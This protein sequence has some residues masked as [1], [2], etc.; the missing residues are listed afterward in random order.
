MITPFYKGLLCAGL[1]Q[2]L[3]SIL[4][5]DADFE[6]INS[7]VPILLAILKA[8]TQSHVE[9][10]ILHANLRDDD[11]WGY[12]IPN[13]GNINTESGNQTSLSVIWQEGLLTRNRLSNQHIM[14]VIPDLAQIN[15]AVSRA[16]IM[17]M[18]T[19][20]VCMQRHGQGCFWKPDITWV[21]AC[22]RNKI[23]RVSKHLLDRYALRLTPPRFK[24]KKNVSDITEWINSE[25]SE[26]PVKMHESEER[27]LAKLTEKIENAV[28]IPSS[29]D[30]EAFERIMD[31]FPNGSSY[32]I[33][34]EST[35]ARMSQA[36]ARLHSSN[37]V[38]KWHVDE[39]ADIIGLV[40]TQDVMDELIEEP[41]DE[42]LELKPPGSTDQEP[43]HYPHEAET[44]II[45]TSRAETDNQNSDDIEPQVSEPEILPPSVIKDTSPYPEDTA[46]VERE[47]FS[48]Q[49][50]AR[51]H[52]SVSSERGVILGDQP[53]NTLTDIAL[54]PT[55]I[56]AAMFQKIRH[57]NDKSLPKDRLVISPADLRR[58]RRQA[59]PDKM[60]I[61]LI[62]YTCLRNCKWQDK[63]LPHL[64]WAY[65]NR[66]NVCIIQVGTED[67]YELH[68]KKLNA[69][70][71]LSPIISDAMD[72]SSG[73][74]TPL[75]HGLDLAYYTMQQNL[76][77]GREHISHTRF[78]VLTDGRGNVPLAV[79]QEGKIKI[80][81]NREG[82]N[83]ALNIA[84]KI[85]QLTK[86]QT[87]LL[88]P[89][90][91]YH[92]ELPILLA[93]ALGA[94]REPIDLYDDF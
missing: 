27:L 63:M 53:T 28:K 36:L 56:E 71:V 22:D 94:D 84:H 64:R 80:P 20:V 31:Y 39:A 8:G 35:L 57:I 16:C 6:N 49:L 54:V 24:N 46:V 44:G 73:K 38:K 2:R 86:V 1:H 32:G 87:F 92:A 85:Y 3:R 29:M 33:R 76:L 55:I 40:D 65:I 25:K 83:D 13:P 7:L 47:Q 26:F 52:L 9:T 5:L 14:V 18:D 61:L 67:G 62:D 70:T 74:A 81:V 45:D 75:A 89:K 72:A 90:P 21:A 59:E 50:P 23:G 78:V 41:E 48:L 58:Y 43:E 12:F 17:L 79:S 91:R 88:D 19:S 37:T 30:P 69:R 34:R 60:L 82:I 68:A 10:V 93:D 51:R 11:L 4:L 77:H 42:D 66:A 15:L